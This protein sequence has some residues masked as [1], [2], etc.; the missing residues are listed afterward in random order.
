MVPPG[1]IFGTWS[2]V[3]LRDCRLGGSG[4]VLWG[5]EEDGVSQRVEV[6]MSGGGSKRSVRTKWKLRRAVTGL[7]ISS[8]LQERWDARPH[9]DTPWEG[10]WFSE[11][12]ILGLNRL[13]TYTSLDLSH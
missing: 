11:K 3:D 7:S 6:H 10:M 1:L 13:V 8:S 4:K 2:E 12:V 9:A 5:G